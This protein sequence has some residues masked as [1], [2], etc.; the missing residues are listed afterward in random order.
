MFSVSVK[1][2]E[3]PVCYFSI[4]FRFVNEHGKYLYLIQNPFSFM[5]IFFVSCTIFD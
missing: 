3:K 2:L 4:V 1:R 5:E